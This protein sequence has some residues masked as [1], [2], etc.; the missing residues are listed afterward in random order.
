MPENDF[1][2]QVQ[3]LFD[4]MRVKPSEKVWPHIENKIKK[5]KIQ[6]RFFIWLPA[7]LV[8]L[9]AGGYWL[10]Q[11]E[12]SNLSNNNTPSDQNIITLNQPENTVELSSGK[13][14]KTDSQ[15]ALA[16]SPD[17]ETRKALLVV[18]DKTTTIDQKLAT[19]PS[20]QTIVLKDAEKKRV[21]KRLEKH[22]R[23]SLPPTLSKE[24]AGTADPIVDLQ[25]IDA[26]TQTRT[27]NAIENKT[28][29]EGNLQNVAL[30]SLPAMNQQHAIAGYKRAEQ[31]AVKIPSPK[32]WEWGIT[33]SAGV[34]SADNGSLSKAFTIKNATA[35]AENLQFSDVSSSYYNQ[36][37]APQTSALYA[38][39]P[40]ASSVKRDFS[41]HAGAFVKRKLNSRLSLSSGLQYHQYTTNRIVGDVDYLNNQPANFASGH[42]SV[43]RYS[44]T[45][46]TGKK[47]TNRY[48]MVELPLG[49]DWLI[50]KNGSLP[51]YLNGGMQL[52]YLVAT[53]SLHYDYK[54]GVYY[55]DES[56]FHKL[57]GGVYAG[58]SARLFPK[59][60]YA[61]NIGPIASYNF[62]N[63]TKPAMAN[64]QN[65]MFAGIH[66]QWILGS[67]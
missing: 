10:M 57:Q 47:Y 65:L 28:A 27:Q 29:I 20:A 54:T 9:V 16:G 61:F 35:R 36:Q 18:P 38:V 30:R 21:G 4:E 39:A 37:L 41:W 62:T 52:S 8:A 51:I 3:R 23:N 43:A 66:I 14:D 22:S 63:L 33:G 58:M 50:N 48:Y 46:V 7:A 45:Y 53:N 1:E 19:S 59:T 55:E 60:P 40:P 6:R 11:T 26:F 56:Y 17:D 5:D 32:V 49:V 13:T 2:K 31:P 44:G 24:I 34:S 42:N 15:R 64:K 12:Q 67:R 25:P